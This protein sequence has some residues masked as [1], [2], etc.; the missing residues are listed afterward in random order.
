MCEKVYS[1]KT[2]KLTGDALVIPGVS[3]PKLQLQ[4]MVDLVLSVGISDVQNVFAWQTGNQNRCSSSKREQP[5]S[6]LRKSSGD[7]LTW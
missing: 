6:V 7:M 3:L 1:R 5:Q 2:V 4:S